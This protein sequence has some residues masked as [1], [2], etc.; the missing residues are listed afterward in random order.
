MT[1]V[2]SLGEIS[3]L[4]IVRLQAFGDDRGRFMETFRKE[5][6]PQRSWDRVQ[7]NR[8]D[9]KKR[10]LR[11][12]HY[13]HRQIDYWYVVQGLLRAALV[14]IRPDS[15]TYL[16]T[17]LIEMGGENNIGLFIPSGVAH[18]FFAISDVTL[19]YVIDNYFDG[20]RDEYGVAWNDPQI[21][22]D[23]G[24]VD[25]ILSDRDRN[26]PLLRDIVEE[27]LP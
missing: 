16:N 18:G 9:S 12:L 2:E 21:G 6:F 17:F 3:G 1:K 24:T 15:A 14:D 10:V 20:G 23:W 11:G 8:S 13:H 5:W 25:P 4:Q 7:M 27:D 26:N 19:T 22:M